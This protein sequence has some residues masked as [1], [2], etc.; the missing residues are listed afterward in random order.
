MKNDDT[1][2]FEQFCDM[3]KNDKKLNGESIE[4]DESEEEIIRKNNSFNKKSNSNQN[5]IA[6]EIRKINTLNLKKMSIIDE[7]AEFGIENNKNN[8]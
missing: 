7:K 2:N 6:S 1:I 3:M 8:V 5:E 4:L